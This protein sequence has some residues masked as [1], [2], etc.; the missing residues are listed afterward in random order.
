MS[1]DMGEDEDD[2]GNTKKRKGIEDQGPIERKKRRREKGSKKR[3][4]RKR[5]KK[6]RRKR[7]EKADQSKEWVKFRHTRQQRGKETRQREFARERERIEKKPT[8]PMGSPSAPTA[9][10]WPTTWRA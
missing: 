8:T 9:G 3:G 10:Q 7:H 2:E 1:K 4:K 6:A 5:R